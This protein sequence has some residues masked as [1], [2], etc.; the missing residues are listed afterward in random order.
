MFQETRVIIFYLVKIQDYQNTVRDKSY[1]KDH[2]QQD[3]EDHQSSLFFRFF[4]SITSLTFVITDGVVKVKTIDDLGV[5]KGDHSKWNYSENDK[6]TVNIDHHLVTYKFRALPRSQIVFKTYKD[7][8]YH[9]YSNQP[10][11]ANDVS[12]IA[13]GEPTRHGQRFQQSVVSLE[14]QNCHCQRRH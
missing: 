11:G 1:E 10:D 4:S 2:G 7:R 5:A 12:D 8:S 6:Q 3:E 9:R 14:G 13:G